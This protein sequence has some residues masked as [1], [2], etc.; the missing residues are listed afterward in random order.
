MTTGKRPRRFNRPTN[1]TLP[2]DVLDAARKLAKKLDCSLSY[3]VESSLREE[4]AKA[5]ADAASDPVD[6]T[7]APPSVAIDPIPSRQP[8]SAKRTA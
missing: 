1:L 2:P 3:L 4:I 8:R 5:K 6:A 7:A